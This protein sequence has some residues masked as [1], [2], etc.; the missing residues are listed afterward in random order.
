MTEMRARDQFPR[1]TLLGRALSLL[2][3]LCAGLIGGHK[4]AVAPPRGEFITLDTGIRMGGAEAARF[5]V[6][7]TRVM[8][9]GRANTGPAILNLSDGDLTPGWTAEDEA[10]WA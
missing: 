5:A 4:K 1:R 10:G 3:G 9:R 7:Y 2:G 6:E 8:V